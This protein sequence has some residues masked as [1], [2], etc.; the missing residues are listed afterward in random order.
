MNSQTPDALLPLAFNLSTPRQN[1][2]ALAHCNQIF[3]SKSS[4]DHVRTTNVD[5]F[6]VLEERLSAVHVSLDAEGK[7]PVMRYASSPSFAYM[8]KLF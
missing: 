7:I 4:E 2:L 3:N 5:S 6:T 8:L 1:R